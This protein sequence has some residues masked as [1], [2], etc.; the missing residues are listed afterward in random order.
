VN[1]QPLN[2]LI[3][4][5][6]ASRREVLRDFLRS[7]GHRAFTAGNGPEGLECAREQCLDLVLVDFK[8]PG[9]E[10]LTVLEKLRQLNPETP[11]VMMTAFGTI[12]TAVRAMK[13]G[14]LDYLT[15]PADLER[16]LILLRRVSDQR[17][18]ERE[19]RL[20]RE[21][22]VRKGGGGRPHHPPERRDGRGGEPGRAGGAQQYHHPDPGR[23]WQRLRNSWPASSTR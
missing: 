2:I 1:I 12:E 22:L 19:N 9:M 7:R 23:E 20:L 21:E 8:M 15:K 10:G 11:V 3:I 5:D 4:E 14:A 18:L 17:T 6:G 13:A 16:L